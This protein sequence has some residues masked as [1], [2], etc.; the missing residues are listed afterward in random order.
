MK[1]PALSALTGGAVG[2]PAA[3]ALAEHGAAATTVIGA[4]GLAV[5]IGAL[6]PELFWLLALILA[7]RQRRWEFR[8][9]AD[10]R[11]DLREHLV[12]RDPVAE[13]V[14][15]RANASDGGVAERGAA[16]RAN[17]S[18]RRRRRR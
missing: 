12:A 8:N 7:A 10:A 2:A 4:T 11:P 15:A 9:L 5:L 6:V 3:A 14:R 1:R 13:I 17:A 16:N 18:G